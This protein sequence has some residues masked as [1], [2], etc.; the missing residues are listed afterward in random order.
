[1]I[2]RVGLHDRDRSTCESG[3]QLGGAPRKAFDSDDTGAGLDQGAGYR[4]GTR[5]DV[6]NQLTCLDLDGV[7]ELFAPRPVKLMPP[8]QPGMPGHGTPSP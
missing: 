2:G 8:P 4:A 3:A 1:M 7:D 6:Y 5:A